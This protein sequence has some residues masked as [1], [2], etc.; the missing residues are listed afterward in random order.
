MDEKIYELPDI[1]LRQPI[2]LNSA[3]KRYQQHVLLQMTKRRT[4]YTRENLL[5]L[6]G[7]AIKTGNIRAH[8]G[9]IPSRNT[10]FFVERETFQEEFDAFFARFHQQHIDELSDITATQLLEWLPTRHKPD[11]FNFRNYIAFITYYISS[12]STGLRIAERFC[13]NIDDF[14][15]LAKMSPFPPLQIDM[16]I[17]QLLDFLVSRRPKA[18]MEIGTASGGTLY[19]FTKV[20]D[21]SASLMSIDLKLAR[22]RLYTSFAR[23]QQQ[24]RVVEGN[25]QDPIMIKKVQET[26]PEGIDFLFIDG[27]HSYEGIKQDFL[28]YTPFVKS[29]G[30]VAFHDIVEDNETRYGVITGGWAGGV[31]KF[32]QEVK[33]KHEHLEFVNN[34]QQD[35]RGIGVVLLPNRTAE[36]EQQ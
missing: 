2:I 16:E 7:L 36:A 5:R 14:L 32:W 25:S 35:G 18:I 4:P 26:F 28:N 20:A 6:A 17:R 12:H 19:L 1:P 21:P 22:P 24:V 33:A 9:N 13:Q 10:A 15:H 29:G 8:K 31:P 27:D 3:L 23:Q 30:V 11:I 34:Y